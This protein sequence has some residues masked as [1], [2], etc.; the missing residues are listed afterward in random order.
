MKDQWQVTLGPVLRSSTVAR[1]RCFATVFG[2]RPNSRLSCASEACDRYI[3]A[4]TANV[5]VA[6]P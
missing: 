4:L 5:V 1:L 6:L 3:V 2:L